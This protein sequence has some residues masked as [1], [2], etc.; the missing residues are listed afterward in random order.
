MRRILA[1]RAIHNVFSTTELSLSTTASHL[2][3]SDPT[4]RAVKLRHNLRDVAYWAAHSEN[5]KWE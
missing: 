4:T 3:L 5:H 2:L 1:A